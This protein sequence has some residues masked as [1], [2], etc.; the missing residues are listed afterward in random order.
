MVIV[1]CHKTH[2]NSKEAKHESFTQR[3]PSGRRVQRCGHRGAV[4]VGGNAV[5]AEVDVEA[6]VYDNYDLFAESRVVW[7]EIPEEE[8][9]E[10]YDYDFV[11]VGG[12]SAGTTAAMAAGDKGAG[13]VALL[14]NAS[15]CISQGQMGSGILLSESDTLGLARFK[16]TW[17]E[18][19]LFRSDQFL[20][21][22]LCQ[23]SGEAMQFIIDTTIAGGWEPNIRKNVLSYED[24]HQITSLLAE[25]GPKPY[26]Y[27]EACNAMINVA[28]EKN[29][30]CY[31][32]CP[33][34]KLIQDESGR[35]VAVIGKRR[36]DEKYIRFNA[37]KGI[38]LATGCFANNQ[39]M[40]KRYCTDVVGFDSKVAGHFGDGHLMG[41]LVGGVMRNGAHSKMVHDNDNPMQSVPFLAV[42]DDG[43][44]FMNEECNNQWVN[45]ILKDQPNKG[46]FSSI[47]DSDYVEQ[48]RSWGRNPTLPEDMVGFMPGTEENLAKGVFAQ[49]CHVHKADTL[50]ELAEQLGINGE[51]LVKAVAR[52][53][54]L[55]EAG[56]DL[57]FGKKTMYLAP[58]KNPPFWGVHRHQRVSA[59][60]SGLNVNKYMQVL[61][62]NNAVIPGLYAAGNT[63]GTACGNCEWY[64]VTSGNSIGNAFTGGYVAALHAT[65]LIGD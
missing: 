4:R 9:E 34:V 1:A 58:I 50:E 53:N 48:V 46:W 61:D 54:E 40:L 26:S 28:A 11:V 12:G 52:Y 33:G 35:V 51:N 38:L 36:D 7:Q 3:I 63:A 21:D 37:A 41:M 49:E 16:Q 65:G 15:V 32:G 56:E 45:N 17:N 23:Y 47:F 30:D 27:A 5:A 13:R 64:Q 6:P 44:R 59:I 8:I 25:Y 18:Q 22:N 10:I 43:E 62:E 2:R 14:Q 31:F 39:N 42:N 24:G 19:N 29:V 60:L 20:L 55:V 57:D